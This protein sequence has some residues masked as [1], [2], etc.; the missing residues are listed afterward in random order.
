M[1]CV[2]ECTHPDLARPVA[3]KVM[4]DS[5]AASQ[6]AV[7]RFFKEARAAAQ[8]RHQHVIEVF[9]VG[10]EGGVPFMVMPFLDGTDL[11]SLL[12]ERG[13]LPLAALIEIFLPILSAVTTAHAAGIV[14]RDLK[15][16]NVMLC[17]RPPNL[18]HPMVLDFGIS[19]SLLE[20]EA[21]LTRS[22]A[23]LGTLHYMAPEL[24]NGARFAT[25]ASDQ[26]ALGVML[27]E[28][29]TGSRPFTGDGSYALMHAIM[30][31][32]VA[33]PSQLNAELPSAFDALVL[34]ALQRD[35][36]Q[37]FSSVSELGLALLDL[38]DR[39]SWA[40]WHDTF[41]GLPSRD[42]WATNEHTRDDA[43]PRVLEPPV[44]RAR[45]HGSDATPQGTVD[46]LRVILAL[47]GAYA[48]GMTALWWSGVSQRPEAPA[49]APAPETT[50]AA[51]LATPDAT[52]SS[53]PA[54]DP[55]IGDERS[56][57]ATI[58]SPPPSSSLSQ[59]AGSRVAERA[60]ATIHGRR[61]GARQ[62]HDV[63]ESRSAVVVQ[64]P[65]PSQIIGTNGA[66]IVE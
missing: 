13:P 57:G 6:V 14:H 29:A 54:R 21:G 35:P 63:G 15:P 38:A 50:A 4:H 66:V 62:E 60:P 42:P 5:V 34:R 27:Y 40:H 9:D 61:S 59:P 33:A 58:S 43:A 26:Y 7:A 39:A 45:G 18:N 52:A 41:L 22:E 64:A 2:F 30:T 46:R 1:G 20:D 32:P 37:R 24:T 28:C 48:I 11:A 49:A 47:L 53:A 65:A 55:I 56:T 44:K 10:T 31:A 16:A 12:R 17:R 3:L 23:L 8:I 51:A 19:K 25:Q 36:Q